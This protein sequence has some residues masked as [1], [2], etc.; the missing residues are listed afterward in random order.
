MFISCVSPGSPSIVNQTPLLG[1]VPSHLFTNHFHTFIFISTKHLTKIVT[2]IFFPIEFIAAVTNA[3]G[4]Y[5]L[6]KIH[7]KMV[8][9]VSSATI[10]C[11][12][13]KVNSVH[14]KSTTLAIYNLDMLKIC[15]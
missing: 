4:R 1:S 6:I 12:F 10:T 7:V 9:L 3:F 11:A 13:V 14:F 15:K 8:T 2:G 5:D